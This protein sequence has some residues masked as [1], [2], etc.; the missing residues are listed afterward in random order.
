MREMIFTIFSHNLI[1]LTQ[2]RAAV[3]VFVCLFLSLQIKKA[4]KQIE[5]K[6][7]SVPCLGIRLRM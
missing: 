4:N 3:L 2:K 7:Q 6:A 5:K 1:T